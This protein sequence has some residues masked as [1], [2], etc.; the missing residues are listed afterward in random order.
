[1]HQACE[2]RVRSEGP[3]VDIDIESVIVFRNALDRPIDPLIVS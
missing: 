3:D 1:M 2:W